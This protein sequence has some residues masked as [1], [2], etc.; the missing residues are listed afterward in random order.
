[1][2]PEFV[3]NPVAQLSVSQTPGPTT[4]LADPIAPHSTAGDKISTS[5]IPTLVPSISTVRTLE[6]IKLLA[7]QDTYYGTAFLAGPNGSSTFMHVG[8]FGDNYYM[9][10]KFDLTNAP[11]ASKF[12]SAVMYL[13]ET[14]TNS[15]SP[16]PLTYRISATWDEST[17]TR[18]VNPAF[19][20]GTS[21]SFSPAWTNAIGWKLCDISALFLQWLN[22]T[23]TNFG[24]TVRATVTSP[25]S[26]VQV[27]TRDA[28]DLTLQPY[29][30]VTYTA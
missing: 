16:L 26:D 7:T 23:Y 14:N 5:V 15:T 22:G 11:A 24:V 27:S 17:L 3:A 6:P 9:F 10:I 30:L 21:Y 19:D 1:M 2:P 20:A 8:G 18:T 25:N 4:V 12:V 29:L 28:A 13:Y